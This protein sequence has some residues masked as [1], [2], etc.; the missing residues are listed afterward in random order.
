MGMGEWSSGGTVL[1]AQTRNAVENRFALSRA[2][3]EETYNAAMAVISPLLSVAELQGGIELIQA[4][5]G[6]IV[7]NTIANTFPMDQ[8]PPMP[9]RP[10]LED[11]VIDPSLNNLDAEYIPSMQQYTSALLDALV[12]KLTTD[13]TNGGTGISTTV[14]AAEQ[15]LNTL[16][17]ELETQKLMDHAEA[18][19]ESLGWNIPPGAV[20]GLRQEAVNQASRNLT[21]SSDRILIATFELEQKNTHKAMDVAVATVGEQVQFMVETAKLGI[22]EFQAK[23]ERIKAII[24]LNLGVAQVKSL[25]NENLTKIYTADIQ[26]RDTVL[27]GMVKAFDVLVRQSEA[28]AN[29]L[30]KKK[31]VE[32]E[33]AVQV[34]GVEKGLVETLAK[35]LAQLCAAW[36]GSVSAG[37]SIS[38]QEQYSAS[39]SESHNW[40]NNLAGG[41]AQGWSPR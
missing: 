14:Q 31:Q 10:T 13:I 2:K 24:Q 5:L 16:R 32:F 34:F 12:A 37:E 17:I 36:V 6:E 40:D 27:Q 11:I 23:I 28:Q 18:V 21:E 1:G 15:E 4:G 8:L 41:W 26:N 25:K 22:L 7:F 19:Y 33:S 20:V 38:L 30:L 39:E 35:V 3:S 29:L 9:M